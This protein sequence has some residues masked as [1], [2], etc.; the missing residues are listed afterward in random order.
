[1][2]NPLTLIGNTW[3]KNW[4]E[5]HCGLTGGMPGFIFR[6]NPATCDPGVPVFCYH[7]INEQTFRSDLSFLTHNGYSTLT[8]DALLD[9]VEARQAAPPRS[10]V[11]SFDD[12][13]QTL[14][15]T[16]YPLLCE[17]DFKA[18]AFICPGL[19][20][21]PNDADA[22]PTGGLCDWGQIKQMHK[23]GH[24]D[25]QPHTDS[26]RYVPSWPRPLPLAGV[27]EAVADQ[28]RPGETPLEE[29]LRRAK[30]VLEQRLGKTTQHMAFPQYYGTEP[31]IRTARDIGYRGFWWGVLPGRPMNRPGDP[32]DHIVRISGEFVRRLPGEGRINRLEVLRKRYGKRI[33]SA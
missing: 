7:V 4:P 1:L 19:H 25:F 26:H 24:I 22:Q 9:H 10:V 27:D 20:R 5:V 29:D 32:A 17:F 2:S 11:L 30:E 6:K 3:R 33:R 23:S 8:A 28:R 14:H 18:V 16:A 15:D 21:E 13:Q 12:G 31:A